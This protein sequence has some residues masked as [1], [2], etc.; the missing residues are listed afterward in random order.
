LRVLITGARGQLG[1]ELARVCTAAGD[2][3]ATPAIDVGD[4]DAV[5]GT[6][7]SARPDVVVHCAAWTAVDACEGDLARAMRDN[8]LACRWVGEAASRAGS[9]VVGLSTDYV[10]SGEQDAPYTEWDE[11]AP[12]SVYGRSKLAGEREL[13]A[14]AGPTAA[15][16]RT[17]WVSGSS[18]SNVVRS[19]LERVAADPDAELAFVDDQRGCPTFVADLAPALRRLAV[20]RVPGLFHVTNDGPTTWYGFVTAVVG[21]AGRGRVRPITTAELDPPRPAPRPAN[22]V[23]AGPAWVGAGFEPLPHWSGALAQLVKELRG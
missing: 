12:R 5:L 14:M 1:S 15:V 19:V 16:V 3:V 18:G 22:S 8:A 23:L 20:A 10:F 4:R 11:P 17:S 7:L 21:L 13:V 6:V 2:D 9:F